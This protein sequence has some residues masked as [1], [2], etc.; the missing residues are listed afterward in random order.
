MV[1]ACCQSK[2]AYVLQ[3]LQHSAVNKTPATVIVLADARGAGIIGAAKVAWDGD[4]LTEHVAALDVLDRMLLPWMVDP[5][6]PVPKEPFDPG[7]QTHAFHLRRELHERALVKGKVK[8]CKP[9][10]V[11]GAPPAQGRGRPDETGDGHDALRDH[12]A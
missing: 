11:V 2:G 6:H 7:D 3:I 1:R 5:A 4:L 12:R 8:V 9:A 10:V